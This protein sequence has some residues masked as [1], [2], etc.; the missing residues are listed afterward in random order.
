[1]ANVKTC[2]VQVMAVERRRIPL[3]VFLYLIIVFISCTILLTETKILARYKIP[4]GSITSHN[5]NSTHLFT[6]ASAIDDSS[7]VVE[8]PT[9]IN[10]VEY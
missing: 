9:M 3:A 10:A 5:R 6:N 4:G 8:G 2:S 7:I 1:M